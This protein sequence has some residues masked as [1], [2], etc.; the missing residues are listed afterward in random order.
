MPGAEAIAMDD[1]PFEQV[2]DRGKRELRMRSHVEPGA[3]RQRAADDPLPVDRS[4]NHI[5]WS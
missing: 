3:D 1:L 2:G 5:R 4:F